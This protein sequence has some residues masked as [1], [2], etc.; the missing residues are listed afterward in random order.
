MLLNNP[1]LGHGEPGAT[2]HNPASLLFFG[3]N[4]APEM[5]GIGPYTTGFA[6]ELVKRGHHVDVV[7]GQPY[8][9]RW[10]IER[11][12]RSMW[13]DSLENGV[14]VRRCP[15]YV[16]R[17]PTFLRRLLHYV[18]FALFAVLPLLRSVRAR[19]PDAIVAIAPA[20]VAAV[21]PF[22][23]ARILRVPFWLH[24]HDFEAELACAT[25][26]VS[27]KSV[28]ARLACRFENAMLRG[29][30][31][32]S[33][34]SDAMSAAVEAKGVPRERVLTLRNWANHAD[35]IGRADGARTRRDWGAGRRTVILYSGNI[36]AK[37]GLDLVVD[38]ARV[39]RRRRDLLFVICGEGPNRAELEM[40]AAGLPN[41]IFR[42]LH[43]PAEF[44]ASMRAADIHLLPQLA[45][46]A[47]LVLPSKLPNMLASGRAV[48]ATAGAGTSLAREV[49]GAG[50]VVPPG[51]A[52][53]LARAVVRL[54]DDREMADAFGAEGR[55]RAAA[56]WSLDL[57]ADRF[58]RR[59]AQILRRQSV[60]V[61]RKAAIPAE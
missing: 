7:T 35:A 54:A 41:L 33:S 44:A 48:V 17:R 4:Y 57:T 9:P 60:S 18:S 22:L 46:A 21:I 12:K 15:L 40:A 43:P 2:A 42:P 58:E 50:L 47:D 32:V 34:V 19:R 24:V 29:A 27:R 53:A 3:I 59:L 5:I 20:L 51:D 39:L 16:P 49:I 14:T 8:Y 26:F 1:P 6:E 52:D 38:A 23:L 45:S 30:A 28:A 61:S 37:Q 36:A 10:R 55:R 25:G 11:A 31:Q 56:R 13:S